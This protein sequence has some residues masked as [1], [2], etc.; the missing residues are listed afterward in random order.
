MPSQRATILD[1]SVYS[2]VTW[3][4]TALCSGSFHISYGA[5]LPMLLLLLLL[6]Q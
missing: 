1:V 3:L 5:L 4:L 6:L 2:E